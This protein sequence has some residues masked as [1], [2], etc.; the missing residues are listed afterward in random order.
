MSLEMS[1]FSGGHIGIFVRVVPNRAFS[2]RLSAIVRSECPPY[3]VVAPPRSFRAITRGW[4]GSRTLPGETKKRDDLQHLIIALKESVREH[5][6]RYFSCLLFRPGY[7]VR[8][9]ELWRKIGN[10]TG[11]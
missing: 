11:A 1:V 3:S 9:L 6:Q 10:S 5:L 8:A 2:Q 7:L 4:W